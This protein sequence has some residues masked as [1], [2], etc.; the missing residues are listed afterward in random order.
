MKHSLEER[1]L[2]IDR[3]EVRV[4]ISEQ[5]RLL[6]LHRSGL[7]YRPCGETEENLKVMKLID[8]FFP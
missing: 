3:S 1:R 2:M 6:S 7:Y 4:S 8:E 5:C